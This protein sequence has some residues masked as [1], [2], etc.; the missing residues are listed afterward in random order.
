[1][2]MVNMGDRPAS[3]ISQTAL[4]MTAEEAKE[5]YPAASSLLMNPWKCSI[6][7]GGN[8]TDANKL[9]KSWKRKDSR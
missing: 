8:E 4:R 1:M 3:A 9:S 7:G 5:D 2:T 6:G